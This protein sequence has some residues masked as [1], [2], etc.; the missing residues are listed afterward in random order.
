MST[1]LKKTFKS[2]RTEA[3]ISHLMEKFDKESMRVK[4]FCDVYNISG[5]TFYNWRKKYPPTKILPSE[6]FIE[7]IPT[8][9]PNDPPAGKL[10]AQVGV[11][12]IYQPVSP[13]YLKSLLA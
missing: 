8:F 3:Q 1:K 2:R 4:D 11:I 9:R 12:Y 13:D 10:F 7:I 5:A 6:G